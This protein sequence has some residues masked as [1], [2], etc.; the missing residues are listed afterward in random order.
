MS[1][2]AWLPPGKTEEEVLRCIERVVR[3]LAPSFAFGVYDVEDICQIG[4]ME[5]IALL[6][7]GK[8]DPTRPLE[9]FLFTHVRRRLLNVRRE[10][11]RTD[12]VGCRGCYRLW[13][14]GSRDA[15]GKGAEGCAQFA[16]WRV[17][18]EKRGKVMR[19]VSVDRVAEH[20]GALTQQDTVADTAAGEELLRLI[21]ERL[22]IDLRGDYLRMRAGVHVRQSRKELVRE[23]V[24][25]ILR[26]AA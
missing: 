16:R 17:G 2:P 5:A 15:C 4:R 6:A 22:P 20:D 11:M 21:D 25:N 24:A 18:Q 9:N 8:Y 7:K 14:A 3:L 19:A 12:S 23:A 13:L 10:F 26:E 1:P